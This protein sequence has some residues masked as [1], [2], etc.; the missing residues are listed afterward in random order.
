MFLIHL[1]GLSNFQG[2]ALIQFVFRRFRGQS[3]VACALSHRFTSPLPPPL[4]GKSR[5]NVSDYR[6]GVRSILYRLFEGQYARKGEFRAMEAARI[7]KM[8]CSDFR[9]I[10]ILSISRADG[11]CGSATFW[12][13]S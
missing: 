11:H 8:P 1:S 9:I 5:Y 13:Y 3:S 4:P 10:N 6:R 12:A 7:T 2:Y